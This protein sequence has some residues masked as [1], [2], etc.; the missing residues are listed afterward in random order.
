MTHS[1]ALENCVTI[2][3]HGLPPVPAKC[4]SRIEAGEHIVVTELLL[5]R[6]GTTRPPA[7]VDPVKT[8]RQRRRALSG[9][10]IIRNPGIGPVFCNL[11]GSTLQKAAS[12]YS[13]YQTP[14]AKSSLEYQENDWMGYVH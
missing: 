3:A 9:A 11:H 2:Y 12:S 13:G 7:I 10:D 4:V 5:D 6:L 1:P 8:G 14:I